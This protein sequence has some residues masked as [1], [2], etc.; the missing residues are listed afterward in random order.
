[1]GVPGA[2]ANGAC[3]RELWGTNR[4][5]KVL[6]RVIYWLILLEV[7]ESYPI[8]NVLRYQLEGNGHNWLWRIEK[9]LKQLGMRNIQTE[10]L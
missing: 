3:G 10:K 2:V 9:E 4:K 7:E 6:E 8:G 5:E 1:M